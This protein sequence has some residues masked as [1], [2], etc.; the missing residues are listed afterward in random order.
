MA[1]GERV[2]NI[3]IVITQLLKTRSKKITLTCN[4]IELEIFFS[5]QPCKVG[6]LLQSS[7]NFLYPT[8]K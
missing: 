8:T 4:F 6:I 7:W 1:F 3:S 5:T 2:K